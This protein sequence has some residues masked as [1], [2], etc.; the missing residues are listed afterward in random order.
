MG[1][2]NLV[3]RVYEAVGPKVE[4]NED[5]KTFEI[6]RRGYFFENLTEA[7]YIL[8]GYRQIKS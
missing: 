8:K 6:V 3:R 4:I 2:K 5:K 7:Y 1:E